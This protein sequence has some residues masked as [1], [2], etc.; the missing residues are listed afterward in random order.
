MRRSV[1]ALPLLL[2]ALLTVN[3][4]PVNPPAYTLGVSVTLGGEE[5]PE[6]VAVVLRVA[7]NKTLTVRFIGESNGEKV[8]LTVAY[9]VNGTERT[10]TAGVDALNVTA[11][12]ITP[13]IYVFTVPQ[14][15]TVG[16]TTYKLSNS[17]TATVDPVSTDTVL[18]V[19]TAPSTAPPSG[20]GGNQPTAPTMPSQPSINTPSEKSRINL[21]ELLVWVQGVLAWLM[22]HPEY[23]LLI[24][25]A[26]L[27]VL[28]AY[29]LKKRREELVIEIG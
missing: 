10:A 4:V 15:V 16:G 5:V 3:A 26:L 21:G 27:V 9:K 2:L 19:Y 20:G 11:A 13:I 22:E 14:N 28:V 24:V 23:L 8:G 1:V 6:P 25:L 17:S 29:Y 7:F 18:F 12:Y